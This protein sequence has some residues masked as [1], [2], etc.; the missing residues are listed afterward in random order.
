MATAQSGMFQCGSCKKN[1][2]RLDHLARHVRSRMFL[3]FQGWL[4]HPDQALQVPCL[5]KSLYKTVGT[6]RLIIVTHYSLAKTAQ[7]DL[8]KRH[9]AGHSSQAGDATEGSIE[10]PREEKPCRRCQGKG[11][12]CKSNDSMELDTTFPSPE[13]GQQPDET[14]FAQDDGSSVMGNFV[15]TGTMGAASTSAVIGDQPGLEILTPQTT[16]NML[17]NLDAS[18]GAD[19]NGLYQYPDLNL[20]SGHWA[21]A[22]TSDIDM[23]SYNALDDM[24]L[25]FLDAY[26]ISIPFEVSSVHPTPTGAQTPHAASHTD[27][28]QPA[29]MCTEAF[30][31]SHWKFRPNAK[32]HSGAEEHNLSLPAA[33]SAYPSPESGVAL[34]LDTRITCAELGN[35]VRDKIL[36]MVVNSCHSDN[37]SKAVAS[38]PSAGLL[39]TLLQYYL[40]SP[41]THA[42]SFLHAASFDPNE[43]RPELVAAM[44]ACGAVLTSDPALSKLGYAIQECL[45]IAISKRWERD[46][47]LVRDLEL[48]Q[49]FL[50]ILEMGIWSGLPRKVEIAESFF[51]PVLT[52]MR[53]DG[54]FKRSAYPDTNS[55][56]SQVIV[57]RDEWL[58][59]VEDESSKRLVFRMLSHDANSSIALLVNPAISY[60]EVLL[61]LPGNTD[62]WTAAS[63]EQWSSFISVQDPGEPLYVADII[64]DPGI[65]NN[66][67]RSLDIYVAIDAVL[68]C[69][70][71][72][73]WEYLQLSSLQ[74]SRPHR[75]NVL[76]TEMRKDELLKLLNHLKLSLPSD[77]LADPEILMRLELTLLH[78]QMPFEDIQIFAGME[79]PE[80]ARAVYP[81]VRDW[82]K[83]EAAR[84]TI[85]HAAQIVRIAKR[86]PKGVIRSPLAIMLYHASLA[87]WVYGLL[88]NQ[89][90][91]ISRAPSQNVCIDDTD[92]IALQRFK[93]F[94][95]GQPCI[96]W[97]SEIPGEDDVV[98]SVPL[99]QPDKVMEAVMGIVRTNFSGLPIPHLTERLVQLMAELKNSAK[100]KVA[101]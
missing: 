68:A 51:H 89:S 64:D 71:A 62:L 32:D 67:A 2:K 44:A 85:C 65:L 66:R 26:N 45:R 52:M 12:E 50:I 16:H 75:W 28:G 13:A 74:R 18:I 92:S 6:P 91:G 20:L 95:Q 94:G 25:R 29:A 69:T 34:N 82:V 98:I 84:H 60:A 40:T 77:E 83:S 76:V 87:F 1:Y 21:S 58:K 90:S 8:L 27:P 49:A 63:P 42:T 3:P 24:D 97:R 30:Q 70:W 57:S 100:R 46:N 14:I 31:N 43:K 11:I 9:V 72:M 23:S 88:S 7:R 41:V 101:A 4:L 55:G 37:L 53:R 86:L 5:P 81:M 35:L 78:L 10:Q 17:H 38:F 96:G 36:M 47:T 22:S 54:K 39:D 80:R 93:G 99:S 15:D 59:W 33:N 19:A 79:G 56:D 48:S 73:C 61:P